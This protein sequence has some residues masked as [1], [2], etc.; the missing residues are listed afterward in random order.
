MNALEKC[1]DM[2][3]AIMIMFLIPLLFYS[4]GSRI[5]RALSAGA[6]CENFLKR[7][8]TAGE[9]TF[10]VWKELEAALEEYGCD[11]F[12][13]RREYTLWEPGEEIGSVVAQ[14]YS[15]EK[16]TLLEQI[17]AEDTVVLHKGDRLRVT[18]YIDNIPTIYYDVIRSE[19]KEE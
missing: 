17:R 2:L 6:A 9:I 19:G 4:G 15:E 11:E 13:V 14:R 8:C 16:D 3:I 10:P 7:V 12:G 1:L 5:V 18:F